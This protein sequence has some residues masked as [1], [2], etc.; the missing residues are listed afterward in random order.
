MRKQ[1]WKNWLAFG[2]AFFLMITV[3]SAIL[4]VRTE[5]MIENVYTTHLTA[6]CDL[7]NYSPP[8]QPQ[9]TLVLA[10]SHTDL[11]RLWPL[12]VIQPWF[13]E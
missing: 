1:N 12:P 11:I 4:N 10:C 5:K 8:A 9:R 6:D 13:E 2:L 3:S 7:D